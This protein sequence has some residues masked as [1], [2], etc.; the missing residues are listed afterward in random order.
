MIRIFGFTLGLLVVALAGFAGE[1]EVES[2]VVRL[3]LFKN[4]LA[5]VR[6][7]VRAVEPGTYVLKDVPEPLH[8][9]FWVESSL[10]VKA[11]LTEREEEVPFSL[12]DAV[13]FQTLLAGRKVTIHFRDGTIPP[14]T[15][16]VARLPAPR[17][18][19]SWGRS[20]GTDAHQ[21][22]YGNAFRRGYGYEPS[23]PPGKPNRPY[24]V[25]RT[26]EGRLFLD[27]SLIAM[28]RSDGG[29]MTVKKRVRRLELIVPPPGEKKPAIHVSYL[30]RGI[31][32]APSYRLDL[33]EGG[34]LEVRMKAVIR[35]ERQAFE[36]VEVELISGFPNIGFSHVPSPLSPETTWAN[37][38]RALNTPRRSWADSTSNGLAY[39]QVARNF[40]SPASPTDLSATP[41]GEGSDI[42]HQ[43]A[44]KLSMTEGETLLVAV[45]SAVTKFERIV[46]WIVPDTRHWNGCLVGEHDRRRDPEKY[47]ASPWDAVRFKNPFDFPMTTGPAALYEGGRFRG[48]S[49]SHWVNAGESTSIRITKALSVRTRTVE[50]EEPGEREI[51]YI[52]GDKHRKTTVRG[53]VTVCNHRAEGITIQIRRRFSGELVEADG[54]PKCELREEGAY[55]VNKRNELI[56]TLTLKPGEERTLEY[57]Y[58]V[59]VDI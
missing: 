28:V 54:E 21:P 33:G 25:L 16:T 24:L 36:D 23:S 6:R 9:T 30:T 26:G 41:M 48:Q 59:M 57:R 56:W 31:S 35:N 12:G 32:W 1:R 11:R 3:G 13:D 5:V 42:H 39:Q 19:R 2:R 18:F 58:T 51:V 27:P 47:E 40:A 50:Q 37:F 52:G 8:G 38:F 10:P 34:G 43:S 49:L 14:A 7:E 53:K 15:G 29:P 22:R 55:S 45:D 4:G 44:G 46:E 20:Y 17:R